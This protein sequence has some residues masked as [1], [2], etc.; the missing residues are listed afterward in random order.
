[1]VAPDDWGRMLQ[2][3]FLEFLD[4]LP[5]ALQLTKIESSSPR[6]SYEVRD[7]FA[8]ITYLLAERDRNPY[9]SNAT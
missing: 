4:Y 7:K 3:F 8:V 9:W 1:M 6:T 5:R 2:I